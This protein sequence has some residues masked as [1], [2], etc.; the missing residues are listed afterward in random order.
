[1]STLAPGSSAT[2]RAGSKASR[3][4]TSE[5]LSRAQ[6]SATNRPWTWNTGSAWSSTSP[7]TQPQYSCSTSPLEIR[8][9]WVIIAPFDR[10][11]V[12]EV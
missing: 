6:C 10:P 11:V 9:P 4:I 3:K 12:P 1:M 8:L 2:S 7:G 5:P